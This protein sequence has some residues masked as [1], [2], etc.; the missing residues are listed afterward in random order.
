MKGTALTAKMLDGTRDIDSASARFVAHRAAPQFVLGKNILDRRT[1]VDRGI[2][3][4]RQ[5][6]FHDRRAGAL[7]IVPFRRVI[8]FRMSAMSTVGFGTRMRSASILS[9]MICEIARLRNHL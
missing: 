8:F 3:R 4:E 9:W 6:L 2:E 1:H 5:D 7:F